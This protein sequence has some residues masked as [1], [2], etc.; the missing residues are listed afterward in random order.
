MNACGNN[1]GG[2]C[3]I[4]MVAAV[5]LCIAFVAVVTVPAAAQ[6]VQPSLPDLQV[7]PASP[8]R[9]VDAYKQRVAM[10]IVQKNSHTIAD[11]LPP[12]LKSVVVLD[13]T[14]DRAG[15]PV[16]VAVRRSNGYHDLEH[17]AI[18]SVRRAG[19]FPAP[20][21]EVLDGASVVSYL[22]TWLFR[23]DG[24]FQVRSIVARES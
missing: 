2:T 24:R 8:A 13:I 23:H 3:G 14:V 4:R 7:L 22:E 18:E 10:Q 6:A 1:F 21:A 20:S 19:P 15:E 12:L 17:V 16:R 5:T 9:T 11:A